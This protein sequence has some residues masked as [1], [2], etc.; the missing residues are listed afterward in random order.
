MKKHKISLPPEDIYPIDDWNI[1]QEKFSQEYLAQDETLF[2]VANGYLGMRGNMEEGAPYGQRGTFINAFYESWPIKYGEKAYGFAEN[3]QTMVNVPDTKNIKIY[4]DDEPLYLPVAQ[5]NDYKRS[6]NMKEGILERRIIW[7]TPTAKKVLIESKRM[8]SME[9]RHLAL[10]T[11]KV[12]LLNSSAN[13]IL[14][15]KLSNVK[16]CSN[17]E[18]SNDP[19]KAEVAFE[20]ILNTEIIR[21]NDNQLVLGYRTKKSKMSLGCGIDHVILTENKYSK[22]TTKHSD[23]GKIIYTFLA[24]EG[25]S[26]EIIK[27]ASYHTS[28]SA[29]TDDLCDRV[30]RTLES[31]ILVGHEKIIAGQKRIMKEFWDR[32]DVKIQGADTRAQQVIRFNLFHIYQASVRTEGAGIGARGLTGSAYGGHYF[33]DSEIFVLP[34]LVYTEPRI[35]RNILKF[36]YSLLD[37]ARDRARQVN[38]KGALFPWR[39]INGEES[40]AYFAAGTA[41]YH[42][43]ADIIYA[44]KKYVNATGD[45]DFLYE[46]GTEMLIETARLWFDLGSFSDGEDGKFNIHGV[47]GPDEYTALVDNNLYTN[48][49]ARDNLRYAVATI[50]FLQDTNQKRLTTIVRET[51]LE[52]SEVDN[53]RKA[54]EQMYLPYDKEK[55]IHPQ[56]DNFLEREK[57]DFENTP[58]DKYPLLLHFHPLVIYRFQ[59]IK[60]ADVVMAMFLLSRQFTFEEKLKNFQY[61]DPITT[62]DSSLSACVQGII[63]AELGLSELASQYFRQTVLM[64]FGNVSGNVDDGAHIAAMGGTWLSVVYGVGGMRD[65]GGEISF[66]PRLLEEMD[67]VK[68]PITIRGQR[69]D[70]DIELEQ[71]TYSLREGTK[72]KF[73][74]IDKE[75][76][77]EKNE[78]ITIKIEAD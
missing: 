23:G 63:A 19:R 34:F 18:I 57:W 8:I 3:G 52:F 38:Q 68:F 13:I 66:K 70:V 74:H 24:E 27:Y 2:T 16:N 46:Y 75:I 1:I 33:W 65:D 43:N 21:A 12:T 11:Y 26:V 56:D 50:C 77:L 5:I 35:A 51:K 54:A 59:V 25:K 15:S 67:R 28:R 32:S 31:S 36:R 55:M 64:D 58:D 73:K 45:M 72:L 39:T 40:S 4:I 7:E 78:K 47:T 6:L 17:E 49:M 20:S 9:Y 44:M 62:G 10:M 22:K 60:Q 76:T 42:I 48:M 29:D 30:E 37:K 71:V 14:S 69:M 53:W 41:Q 61:Y